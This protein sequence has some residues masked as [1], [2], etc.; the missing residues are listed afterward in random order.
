MAFDIQLSFDH[1]TTRTLQTI[2]QLLQA[3]V[4]GGGGGSNTAVINKLNEIGG[5]L[6]SLEA[7]LSAQDDKIQAFVET[8]NANFQQVSASLDT[9]SD[10]V[11]NIAADEKNL[12]QMIADL[13]ASTAGDL[14][15]ANATKLQT[16][17]DAQSALVTKS[18]AFAK[19]AQDLAASIPDV[20]PAPAAAAKK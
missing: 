2:A 5:Q 13:Q 6:V 7:H 18:A 10:G 4:T 14:S 12:Q 1:Q 11:D 16:I 19:K 17:V 8:T 3:L 9:I 20:A 15:P